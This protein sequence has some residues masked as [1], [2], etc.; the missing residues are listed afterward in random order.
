LE[1]EHVKYKSKLAQTLVDGAFTTLE[2]VDRPFW[3]MAFD[4]SLYLQSKLM[5]VREGLKGQA[6]R[7][8]AQRYFENPTEEMVLRATDDAH[9]ATFKDRGVLA[10]AAGSVKRTTAQAADKDISDLSGYE[11]SAALAKKRTAAMANTALEVTVPFTGVPSSVTGKMASLSPL[12][13]LNPKI[14]GNQAERAR[15]LANA[16]V[17]TAILAAAIEAYKQG[18]VTG[19]W[20]S[21][22]K[23]RAQWVEEGKQPYSVKIG[24]YW[25]GIKTLGPVFAAQVAMAAALV[26]AAQSADS[27]SQVVTGAVGGAVQF[28]TEQT[29]LKTLSDI[30]D[31]V[32]GE[33]SLGGVAAGAVPVPALIGQA[34][35]AIDPKQRDTR[36]AK[37]RLLS[38]LP[39]GTFLTPERLG[40]GGV[41]PEKDVA[42]RASA[43]VSPFPLSKS[44][45]TE[46]LREMRRLDVAF[47]MPGKK[48]TREGETRR[49]SDR[50]YRDFVKNAGPETIAELWN[51]L[52]DS[53]YATAPDFE[54]KAA[55][56]A[57][58]NGVRMYHREG[59]KSEVFGDGGRPVAK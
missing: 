3:R 53:A 13:L 49:L 14:L 51:V 8:A 32:E 9:Y 40:P 21:N 47:T 54:R 52:S 12:G 24:N 39:G 22:A 5:A 1:Y 26:D 59:V 43:V 23:E 46:L 2:A 29:Y 25:V 28:L 34:N 17:G 36:G 7:A 16:G 18:L 56:Q 45:D 42:E 10:S 41:L 31:A 44:R 20:P 37:N 57:I 38:K 11:R 4:G 58:V 50:Q 19:G 33:A 30:K 6:R 35:R 27:P 15:V 48:V 55:L